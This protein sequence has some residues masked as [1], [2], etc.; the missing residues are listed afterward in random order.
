[1]CSLR[2]GAGGG[3]EVTAAL[4]DFE[5]FIRSYQTRRYTSAAMR[6]PA[7]D[8]SD[9]DT[10]TPGVNWRAMASRQNT[11]RDVAYW[12][13]PVGRAVP[14]AILALVIT[15]N[16]DHS[17]LLGFVTF[18]IFGVLTGLVVGILT[19]RTLEPGI[20]RS[21]LVAQAA[22]TLV[23]G[24][25]ALLW[26]NAGLGFLLFLLSAW[27]ALTGFLELYAGYRARRRHAA[28]RDWL[29]MGALTVVFALVVL[30]IPPDYRQQFTGPDHVRRVLNTAVV[31]I[32]VLGAYGAIAT[33]YLMIAG[34]SLKW[35]SATA[36]VTAASTR[37]AR[38]GAA[39]GGA[40]SSGAARHG[41]IQDGAGS[42]G[43][44]QETG[45][46]DGTIQDG[47]IQDGTIQDGTV[48]H[49]AAQDGPA[50]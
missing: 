23:A 6:P 25:V 45:L 14:A 12:Y 21:V 37:A 28:S 34:L 46:Q 36:S 42:S 47:T 31:V 2:G 16:A 11:P 1:M 40:G 9:V 48:Q 15:F 41:T 49:R 13:V 27:G 32:G 43:A 10:A 50:S 18:G 5:R 8:H 29:F 33:V 24:A 30:V 38:G 44:I 35:S 22:V 17:P 39:R 4:G 20:G 26:P 3:G 7:P 19:W